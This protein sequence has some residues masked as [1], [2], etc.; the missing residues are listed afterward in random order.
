MRLSAPLATV[1]LLATLSL[2]A[3]DASAQESRLEVK[4]GDTVR[5]ILERH[6]GK[7]VALVVTNGPE[8]TGVVTAVGDRLVHLSELSGRD[9]FDA[10]VALD[11]VAAVIVRVRGR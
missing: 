11:H 10:A 2:V 7:R 3:P 8:L 9:F 1:T 6:V 4:S 5:S